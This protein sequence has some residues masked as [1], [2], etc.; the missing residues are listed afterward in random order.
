MDT[1]SVTLSNPD[2]MTPAEL[3]AALDRAEKNLFQLTLRYADLRFETDKLCQRLQVMCEAS[4]AGDT[5]TVLDVAGKIAGSYRD[6]MNRFRT[7]R[8]RGMH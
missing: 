1:L 2:Q 7:E 8:A 4:L 5:A 3:R 6:N